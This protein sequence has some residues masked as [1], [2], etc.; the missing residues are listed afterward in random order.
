[1]SALLEP[2]AP[3]EEDS[4]LAR[5][6]SKR[7]LKHHHH[8]TIIR[9]A[10][11]EEDGSQDIVEIPASAFR[12]FE[13]ILTQ[14][15]RGNAVTLTPYHHLMTTQQAANFLNVSR[16]FLIKLLEEGDIPHHRV[17]RHRRI[18]FSDMQAYKQKLNDTSSR[19]LEELDSIADELGLDD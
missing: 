6:S 7:L 1:M 8:Q 3:S 18:R 5:E 19:A 2:I 12:L 15:A 14:M 9:V 10:L 16:P 17:G 13:E 4:R 11:V